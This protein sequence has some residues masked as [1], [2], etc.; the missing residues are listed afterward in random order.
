MATNKVVY[1]N[2]TL[3][4]LTNDTATEADVVSGKTFHKKNGVAATGTASLAKPEQTKTVTA[5]TS[6]QIVTPD[7][8]K[9]L[10]SV[11]V[12]PQN[13]TETYTP[14]A[15]TASN[16]MGAIH[17][18]RYVNT[19]G[20]YVPTS[21]TPSNSSPGTLTAG[22]VYKPSANGRAIS[23]YNTVTPFDTFPVTMN[24]NKFYKK[25]SELANAVIVGGIIP[26]VT[27][28]EDGEYFPSGMVKMSASGYAFSSQKLNK[29]GRAPDAYKIGKLNS[30][31][32]MTLTVTQKPKFIN[33]AI[34]SNIDTCMIVTV[35]VSANVAYAIS[36][37]SSADHTG[38]YT[39][40]WKNYITTISDTSVV[41]K[42]TTS[43][44][45]RVL[46]SCYYE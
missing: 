25:S 28:S 9:V 38:D 6:Q 32:S 37:Y 42:N 31:S 18:K 16:D 8:G 7:N 1:G 11:T 23:D 40:T 44:Q 35:D 41:F 27:P 43:A 36:Y 46:L 2:T 12:N 3:I 22:E 4:D 26:S 33:Y 5:T 30:G 13:H 14:A 17:N 19:S 24:N 21:I 45:R 20:M 29:F 39:S 10:S 34:F 15:N